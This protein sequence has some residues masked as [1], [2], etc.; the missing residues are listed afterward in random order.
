MFSSKAGTTSE[1]GD[2]THAGE[3]FFTWQAKNIL[4]Y[5]LIAPE[6]LTACTPNRSA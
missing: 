3:G 5:L 1:M 2:M 4:G 6:H